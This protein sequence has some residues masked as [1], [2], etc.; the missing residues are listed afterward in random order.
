[1]F[2]R[3]VFRANVAVYLRTLLVTIKKKTH[4]TK[5]LFKSVGCAIFAQINFWLL[6]YK[7]FQWTDSLH[8]LDLYTYQYK[9]RYLHI[10]ILISY[11]LKYL[12]TLIQL[13]IHTQVYLITHEPAIVDSYL[14]VSVCCWAQKGF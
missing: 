10:R 2:L 1:V 4:R 8:I 13:F 12:F 14:D 5:T 3:R 9:K 7:I 11:F 6:N